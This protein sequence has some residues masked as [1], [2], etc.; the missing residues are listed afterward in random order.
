MTTVAFAVIVLLLIG[1]ITWAWRD[2][3]RLVRLRD[4]GRHEW[5]EDDL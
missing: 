2:Y 5:T 3:R 1:W 4:Q